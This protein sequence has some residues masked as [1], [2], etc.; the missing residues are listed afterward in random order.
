MRVLVTGGAGFVG[1]HLV[2]ALLG[3]GHQ[4]QLPDSLE[5]QVDGPEGPE[6]RAPDH[7]DRG[8]ELQ[9]GDVRDRH[10]VAR[11]L[12]GVEAVFHFAAAVGVGQSMYEMERH[13]SINCVGAAVPLEGVV[14]RR[15]RIRKLILASSMS[16]YGEGTYRAGDRVDQARGELARRG[17]AQ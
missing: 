6:G 2:D 8:A 14:E 16:A 4:V 3:R 7:L 10:A 13:V 12:E 9:I 17:L 5:P 1:S 15:E 11:A